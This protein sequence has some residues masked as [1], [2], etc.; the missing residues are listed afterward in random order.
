MTN[1]EPPDIENCRNIIQSAVIAMR[2]SVTKDSLLTRDYLERMYEK[3]K[4]SQESVCFLTSL[5]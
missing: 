5:I 4:T 2:V 3:L 1:E